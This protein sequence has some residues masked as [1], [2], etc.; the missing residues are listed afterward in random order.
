MLLARMRSRLER[1]SAKRRM[2]H[3]SPY[4]PNPPHTSLAPPAAA[5]SSKRSPCVRAHDMLVPLAAYWNMTCTPTTE[6][7]LKQQEELAALEARNMASL[8]EPEDDGFLAEYFTDSA[9]HLHVITCAGDL[10]GFA[11][12]EPV[13]GRLHELHAKYLRCGIGRTLLLAVE[14]FMQARDA[15]ARTVSVSVHTANGRARRFYEANGF[16]PAGTPATRGMLSLCK[17]LPALGPS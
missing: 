2:Q 10:L 12:S 8:A 14:A 7:P 3:S 13:S 17:H 15:N 16:R 4:T 1:A 5:A 11:V 6:A 9:Y